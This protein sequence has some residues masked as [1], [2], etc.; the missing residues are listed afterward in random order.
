M[1]KLTRRAAL[2]A[3]MLPRVAIA[4]SD[5][6]P[7]ITVAVQ[8]IA[9]TNTTDPMREQSSN[10]SERWLGS[11]LEN[12]IGRNSG[13]EMKC[14]AQCRLKIFGPYFSIT[15]AHTSITTKTVTATSVSSAAATAV[16]WQRHCHHNAI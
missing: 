2:A 3:A 1:I 9:N 5:N 16:L 4:Q 8:K 15:T 12:L 6:R 13:V 7:S 14:R 10:V 11:I